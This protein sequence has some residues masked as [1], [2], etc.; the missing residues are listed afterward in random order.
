[1]PS[2][3]KKQ[4]H[5]RPKQLYGRIKVS[6]VRNLEIFL[7]VGRRTGL[8]ILLRIGRRTGLKI[9]L[10]IGRAVRN[11]VRN[12][13]PYGRPRRLKIKIGIAKTNRG[14]I[15]FGVVPVICAVAS[16]SGPGP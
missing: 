9:F 7:H 15:F 14:A 4:L 8:K 16:A 3:K 5:G 12:G 6:A 11:A 2:L 1:M 10:R 13:T